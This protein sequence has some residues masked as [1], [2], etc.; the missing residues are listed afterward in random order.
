MNEKSVT[1]SFVEYARSSK[2]PSSPNVSAWLL[3]KDE[4][5]ELG[6]EKLGWGEE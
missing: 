1:R 2:E 5:E 6:E 4:A 3:S